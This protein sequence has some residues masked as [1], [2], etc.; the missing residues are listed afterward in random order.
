MIRISKN[1]R[2]RNFT[3]LTGSKEENDRNEQLNRDKVKKIEER[4][5]ALEK[6]TGLKEV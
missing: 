4:L 3:R 5:M 1:V 2:R 6:K